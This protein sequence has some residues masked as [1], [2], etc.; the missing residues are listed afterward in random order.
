MSS[1]KGTRNSLLVEEINRPKPTVP[2][3]F[4]THR[5]IR[6]KPEAVSLVSS[7]PGYQIMKIAFGGVNV[8]F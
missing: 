1:K 5:Q 4:L 2:R 3:G 6:L 8:L 7:F